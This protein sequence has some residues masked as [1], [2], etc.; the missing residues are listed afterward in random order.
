MCDV[1][2][3]VSAK[4]LH[5]PELILHRRM[6]ALRRP[7]STVQVETGR[8]TRVLS[9]AGIPEFLRRTPQV[10]AVLPCACVHSMMWR[11]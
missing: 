7:V 4:D 11:R 1:L 8:H 6:A 10:S 9:C 2:R 5:L 3:T